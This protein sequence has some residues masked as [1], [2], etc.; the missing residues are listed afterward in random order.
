MIKAGIVAF[1]RKIVTQFTLYE[2]R[3]DVPLAAGRLALILEQL[4][5][6]ELQQMWRL[7]NA[8]MK[9]AGALRDAGLLLGAGQ[10]NEVAYR[11]ADVSKSAVPVAAAIHGWSDEWQDEIARMLRMT[12]VPPFPIK[13]QDLVDAGLKEGPALGRKLHALERDWIDSGFRLT[14]D[15]LLNRVAY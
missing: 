7:S 12:R 10:I 6:V 11:F 14:R 1:E 3:T 5:T 4:G 2:T 15:E 9:A 8:E 13:G